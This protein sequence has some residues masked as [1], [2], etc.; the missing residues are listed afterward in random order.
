V[1]ATPFSEGV[2]QE[3]PQALQEEQVTDPVHRAVSFFIVCRQ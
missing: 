2:W 3:A 1:E